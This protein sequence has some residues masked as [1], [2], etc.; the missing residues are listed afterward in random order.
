MGGEEAGPIMEGMGIKHE[1]GLK[2]E[3]VGI[4]RKKI[5]EKIKWK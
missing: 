1:C 4:K 3:K 2:W 5:K